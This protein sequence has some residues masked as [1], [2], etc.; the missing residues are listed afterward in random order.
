MHMSRIPRPTEISSENI[1]EQARRN[2][3]AIQDTQPPIIPQRPQH[4]SQPERTL[5]APHPPSPQRSRSHSPEARH[6]HTHEHQHSHQHMQDP[7][8]PPLGQEHPSIPS[9]TDQIPPKTQEFETRQPY[10][11]PKHSDHPSYH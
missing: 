4:N 10:F 2:Y 1:L 7:L 11:Q 5:T 3:Y 8:P 9:A 6:I